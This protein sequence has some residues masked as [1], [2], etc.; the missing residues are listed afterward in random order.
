V[1]VP[2]EGKETSTTHTM[3]QIN[4]GT[5]SREHQRVLNSYSLCH[6]REFVIFSSEDVFESAK[7]YADNFGN[8]R[9]E[10]WKAA[11]VRYEGQYGEILSPKD[12][13]DFIARVIVDN[14]VEHNKD[15]VIKSWYAIQ[16]LCHLGYGNSDFMS[17][18]GPQAQRK[19]LQEAF[20]PKPSTYQ[21]L[22]STDFWGY[23]VEGLN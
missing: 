8:E 2:T 11:N 19:L 21:D 7:I 9:A 17:D 20:P 10:A 18:P 22:R 16:W 14:S 23:I 6:S 3:S 15:N 13:A 12:I 4:I 5:L 1:Y